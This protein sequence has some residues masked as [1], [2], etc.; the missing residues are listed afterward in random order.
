MSQVTQPEPF[1]GHWERRLHLVRTVTRP[2]RYC[3]GHGLY[4]QVLPTGARYVAALVLIV[5]PRSQHRI[6]P[7]LVAR[8]LG[9]TPM[10]SRIAVGLAEGKRVLSS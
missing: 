10:E 3:D 6:D 4:L 8:T 7:D 5:E 1:R 9:L 2:G